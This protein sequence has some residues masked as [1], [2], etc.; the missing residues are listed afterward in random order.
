MMIRNYD[1]S[2]KINHTQNSPYIP[3]HP[4]IIGGSGS[5]FTKLNEKMTRY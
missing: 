3:D 1:K 4:S 5:Y 2:A